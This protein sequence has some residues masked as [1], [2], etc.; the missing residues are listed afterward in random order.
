MRK[1]VFIL[2]S[3][4]AAYCADFER[5][6][7]HTQLFFQVEPY[8][9]LQFE[10]KGQYLNDPIDTKVTTVPLSL[11]YLFNPL[12]TPLFKA[13]V[14][15]TL[16]LGGE[17][18]TFQFGDI[19][20]DDDFEASGT[21]SGKGQTLSFMSMNPA[22]LA[23]F[24]F[25]IAGNLDIRVLG[26]FGIQY[27]RFSNE[28]NGNTSTYTA[29][30]Q[31]MYVSGAL[32]YKLFEIFED[33]DL[34]I[35]IN[36][37]KEFKKL[38]NIR[39]ST[40]YAVDQD[41][42]SSI[43][44]AYSGVVFSKIESSIP[45]RIALELSLDFGRESRRDRKVR[46]ALHDR[47]GQ[48]RSNSDVKDTVTDWDCMAIERDYRFFLDNGE[49]PDVSEKYTKAQFSDVLESYL[50]YCHPEDL[51]TKEKLYNALDSNKV[52]LKEYQVY[53]EDSRYDQVMASND[54]EMMEMYLQYYP[55][56]PHRTEVEAKVKVLGDYQVFKKAQIENSFKSYLEYLNNFPNGSFR[57]EAEEGIFRLVQEGNRVKDYEIYLRRF[58]EGKYVSD[59][60]RALHELKRTT[61]ASI[62]STGDEFGTTEEVA[63]QPE[64]PV[65]KTK[66]P[67]KSKKSKK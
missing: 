59:A 38:E 51:A 42:L 10:G 66:A 50:A 57:E 61:G 41:D 12:F 21:R 36:V 48:L 39:A 11:G 26:G 60:K 34:K 67:K 1:I 17:I 58:P 27:F 8:A 7:W 13:D 55:D 19:A 44:G 30:E 54:V 9:P 62:S 24:A 31:T 2:L 35:G 47:D 16:W 49:L 5:S 4:V 40:D 56:S 37:R 18:S 14:P 20:S 33:T 64:Q 6:N 3:V 65:K 46:F 32:E 53:Q 23:G 28:Q 45:V 63:P 52:S 43:P 22:G 15:F 29:T 25:N